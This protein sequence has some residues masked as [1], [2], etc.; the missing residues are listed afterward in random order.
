MDLGFATG[1]GFSPVSPIV[2]GPGGT[3]P[4]AVVGAVE[5]QTE[6]QTVSAQVPRW[7]GCA[8][9][10]NPAAQQAAFIA[11]VVLVAIGWHLHI[12]SLME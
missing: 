4:A 8:I 11:A 2:T 7:K 10:S 9:C 5:G 1:V 12:Y 6:M 3:G